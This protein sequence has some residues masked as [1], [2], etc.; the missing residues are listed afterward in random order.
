ASRIEDIFTG[1]NSL[2]NISIESVPDEEVDDKEI[3][4]DFY[5][6]TGDAASLSQD[7]NTVQDE[8][9]IMDNFEETHDLTVSDELIENS[10]DETFMQLDETEGEI[11]KENIILEEKNDVDSPESLINEITESQRENIEIIAETDFQNIKHDN[12]LLDKFKDREM[13]LSM[14]TVLL[15][16]D[17][18]EKPSIDSISEDDSFE[19]SDNKEEFYN[20]SGESIQ[21]DSPDNN[22]PLN[23][24]KEE[25]TDEN[26]ESSFDSRAEEQ[27][28]SSERKLSGEDYQ[29]VSNRANSIPDHVL[30]PTLADIY[31]QQN[32]PYVAIQIYK[33]LFEM[34]PENEHIAERI[35]EIESVIKEHEEKRMEENVGSHPKSKGKKYSGSAKKKDNRPLKGK[36]IKK[37]VKERIKKNKKLQ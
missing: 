23:Y 33:R 35:K 19:D 17:I 37:K 7:G 1:G 31:F 8:N 4:E 25:N 5:T 10:S 20:V 11:S 22:L 12:D 15:N 3:I 32:Q 30:T 36:K 6:E 14:D 24:E 16:N 18:L 27:Y 29:T 2:E 28:S 34:N 9:S 21:A 13:Y 26:D